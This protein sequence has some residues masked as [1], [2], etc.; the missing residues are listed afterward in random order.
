MRAGAVAAAVTV[1][2]LGACTGGG[3]GG[4][5]PATTS[6]VPSDTSSSTSSTTVTAVPTTVPAADPA[7]SVTLRIEDLTVPDVRAGGGG[8][9]VLVRASSASL[10]VRRQG[11]GGAVAVCPVSGPTAPV[12]AGDCADLGAGATVDVP[13]T[14]GLE[15]RA[16]GA[17]AEVDE[18]GIT[19]VPVDRSTTI[20]TP[21]RPAGACPPARPC[22][23][24]YSMVPARPGPFLLDGRAGGGRPRLVLVS[25]PAGAGRGPSRV[26]ETV[27]GG[28][29][30]SI[31]AT[32]EP[33]SEATLFHHE[34]GDGPVAPVTAEISWP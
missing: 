32:L 11:A 29:S 18:V 12:A 17:V 3:T 13:F 14:V 34:Q 15:L 6:T 21:A 10:R 8:L 23:T 5:P 31:R 26:L 33:G 2:V 4:G 22:E 27:E 16:S 20:I 7:G 9:R 28:G 30:L 25:T 1:V 24:A 19:Y